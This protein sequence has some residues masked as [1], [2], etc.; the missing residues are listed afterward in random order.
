MYRIATDVAWEKFFN[1]K[2]DASRQNFQLIFAK[3]N[4]FKGKVCSR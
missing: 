3:V 4:K 2:H 1:M